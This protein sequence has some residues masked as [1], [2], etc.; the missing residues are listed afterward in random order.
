VCAVRRAEGAKDTPLRP[1]H[2]TCFTHEWRSACAQH[3]DTAVFSTSRRSAF[4]GGCAGARA[5]HG[6]GFAARWYG[7]VAPLKYEGR[8]R[9]GCVRVRADNAAGERIQASRYV[10]LLPLSLMHVC[11][12]V[13]ACEGEGEAGREGDVE[14]A[15]RCVRAGRVLPTKA[16]RPPGQRPAASA[17]ARTSPEGVAVF[18]DPASRRGSVSHFLARAPRA[19]INIRWSSHPGALLCSVPAP[20]LGE[21]VQP[22]TNIHRPRFA[23]PQ[24]LLRGQCVRQRVAQ[25]LLSTRAADMSTLARV[26]MYVLKRT[27]GMCHWGRGGVAAQPARVRAQHTPRHSRR[28]RARVLAR[29][30]RPC[31]RNPMMGIQCTA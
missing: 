31:Q 24:R 29:A 4:R 28:T 27:R 16:P 1:L 9:P 10:Q 14:C 26:I 3:I 8:R 23:R 6:G 12:R 21:R 11:G 17:T 7:G 18:A 30:K 22:D 13:R 19:L 2:S 25:H 20:L 15:A 5:P